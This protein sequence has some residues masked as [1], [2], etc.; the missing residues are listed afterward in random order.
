MNFA[1]TSAQASGRP[2]IATISI[3]GIAQ[4]SVDNAVA[5]VGFH[6][7]VAII[8]LMKSVLMFLSSPQ[9]DYMLQCV[10]RWP[11][12]EILHLTPVERFLQ[13]TPPLIL[14]NTVLLGHPLLTLLVPLASQTRKIFFAP[15]YQLST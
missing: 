10:K 9:E 1:L 15:A 2:S 6:N 7:V 8:V 11:S 14:A 3:G 13:G 4:T 12:F 5:A